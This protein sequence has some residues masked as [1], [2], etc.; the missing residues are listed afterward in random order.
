MRRK[1]PSTAALVSFESAA[2]HESFTKAAEELS[3]TQ[4][5]I[6][7]QI[8]TLEELHRVELFRSAR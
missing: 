3:L 8:A 1:I 4:S 5:A 6:C 2:R 7:R